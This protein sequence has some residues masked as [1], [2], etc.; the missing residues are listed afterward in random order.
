MN[1]SEE[2]F[3][4][5]GGNNTPWMS[6]TFRHWRWHGMNILFH[7][8]REWGSLVWP[9]PVLN[10]LKSLFISR[11]YIIDTRLLRK[12]PLPPSQV[13]KVAV[14]LFLWEVFILWCKRHAIGT[15]W[16]SEGDS[17]R[18]PVLD[19]VGHD[20]QVDGPVAGVEEEEH[21]GEDVGGRAVEAQLE[22]SQLCL[23][24]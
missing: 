22:P 18:Y 21:E 10:M 12:P 13:Q 8:I 1:W 6:L 4:S 15:I 7:I 11:E 9:P 19:E 16:A 2:Q 23:K 5:S 3:S 14:V 17:L 24:K 20:D